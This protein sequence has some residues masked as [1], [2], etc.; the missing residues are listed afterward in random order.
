MVFKTKEDL[1]LLMEQNKPEPVVREAWI[2]YK[3]GEKLNAF[4]NSLK[5][6]DETGLNAYQKLYPDT[7]KEEIK[8]G[9][10]VV[11]VIEVTI[12]YLEYD[13]EEEVPVLGKD[14]NPVIDPKTGLPKTELKPVFPEDY[15]TIDEN[16]NKVLK[17]EY[18]DLPVRPK[19]EYWLKK[20]VDEFLKNPDNLKVD[21]NEYVPFIK[22]YLFKLINLEFQKAMDEI[23]KEYPEHEQQ[24]WYQQYQEA[25]DYKANPKT[26]KTPLIDNIALARNI[27]K[28][29]LVSKI[30]EKAATYALISGKAIGY[31]QRAFKMV[32]VADDIDVLDDV[33]NVLEENRE[34]F[35]KLL[36]ELQQPKSNQTTQTQ[37]TNTTQQNNQNTTTQKT[38][39]AQTTQQ[40]A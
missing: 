29:V 25:K 37:K 17:P 33:L 23:T 13:K 18:K 30:L 14:G 7:K 12:R 28:D 16:G 35:Y 39:K 15:Y 3:K 34:L 19:F 4:I 36:K 38:T 8:V 2:S 10:T 21:M 32:E 20:Q 9:N 1:N 26:A 40:K 27:S 31:R 24:T 11:D 22:P 6:P 5:Q